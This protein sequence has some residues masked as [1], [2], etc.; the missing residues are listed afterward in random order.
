MYFL[1]I[2][3]MVALARDNLEREIANAVYNLILCFSF[4]ANSNAA[5]GFEKLLILVV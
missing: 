5:N 3:K 1:Y 2:D 4:L